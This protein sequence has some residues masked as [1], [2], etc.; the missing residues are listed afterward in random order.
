MPRVFLCPEEREA[1]FEVYEQRAEDGVSECEVVRAMGWLWGYTE[2]QVLYQIGNYCGIRA[3]VFRE[4]WQLTEVGF[5]V[6][7]NFHLG[8]WR[9]G[10]RLD[11]KFEDFSVDIA[12]FRVSHKWQRWNSVDARLLLEIETTGLVSR[13]YHG[14]T[15]C[16]TAPRCCQRSVLNPGI[17]AARGIRYKL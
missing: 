2:G 3:F 6:V 17:S 14:V 7:F 13:K 15:R 11:A 12:R 5:S 10:G 1:V 16:H 9:M 8:V 4:V